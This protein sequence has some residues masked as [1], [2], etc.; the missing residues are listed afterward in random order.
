MNENYA[1]RPAETPD[2]AA[3]TAFLATARYIHRHLDWR[4]TLDWIGHRPFYLLEERNRIIALLAY[5]QDP[6][7]ISWIR[8]F[9]TAPMISPTKAWNELFSESIKRD[10]SNRSIICAVGLQEWFSDLLLANNFTHFQDIIILL[11]N[12]KVPTAQPLPSIF[13]ERSMHADDIEA[14]ARLDRKSFEALW[15]N[16]AESIQ[17]AFQQS[18][19][20]EVIEYQGDIVGYQISTANQFSAHLARLA[21]HP[22]F[23]RHGLGYQMVNSI[24]LHYRAKGIEQVTVNTQRNNH[25]S[26]TLYKKLGFE[27]TQEHYPVLVYN[28]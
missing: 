12:R 10:E 7:G 8:C 21:V 4:S 23:Q 2:V 6:P 16:S 27:I 19:F 3:V 28:R 13:K 14:V 25:S 20:A 18:D 26:L 15:V 17:L 1:V 11:W 22:D 5:P 9:A 24:I